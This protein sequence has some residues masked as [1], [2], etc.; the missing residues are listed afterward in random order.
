DFRPEYK[1]GLQCQMR[2]KAGN[3]I[4]GEGFPFGGAIPQSEWITLPTDA[5]I[6]LRTTP[7]GLHRPGAIM[8]CAEGT[9][10]WTIPDDDSGETF[11]SGPSTADPTKE[12]VTDGEG[13]VWRGAIVL[14]PMKIVSRGTAAKRS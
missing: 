4:P 8:V 2:D 7:F 6:R 10:A 13:H 9:K 5:S 1:Q 14:P 3:E 12:Q 11:L